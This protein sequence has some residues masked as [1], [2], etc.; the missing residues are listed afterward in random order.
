[1]IL[2]VAE[3]PEDRDG[4]DL[5]MFSRS[6]K[7]TTSQYIVFSL[8]AKAKEETPVKTEEQKVLEQ[9]T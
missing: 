4:R 7:S 5:P 2:T 3:K 6:G 8:G 9:Q 1:M